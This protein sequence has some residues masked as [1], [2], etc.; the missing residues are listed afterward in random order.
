MPYV[1][2]NLFMDKVEEQDNKIHSDL[3]FLKELSKYSFE[4]KMMICQKYSSR[5]MSCSEVDMQLA[6]K[7]NIMPWELETFAAFSV[8]YNDE[9]VDTIINGEAFAKIITNIRNYWHPELSLAEEQGTYPNVF[10]MIAGLHEFPVQGLILQKLFRY[11]YFFTFSNDKIDMNQILKEN[12]ETKYEDFSLFAFIVF[13]LMNSECRD[14]MSTDEAQRNLGKVF[15]LN[16]VIKALSI[17]IDEYKRNLENLYKGKILDYY[18]GLKIQYWYPLISGAEFTYIPSPYLIINAVTESL[19]NRITLNNSKLRKIFGKEI[20]ESYLYDLYC[21]VS[22]ITWI[23][24]EI[25]YGKS[26]N[27]TSDVLVGEGEFCTF[28]DTKALTPSLKIRQFDKVE[29][30]NETEIYAKAVIQVYQQIVNY[31]DGKFKLE[32]L[33][34]KEHLFGV[35]VVLEDALLPR[36]LIY[37]MAFEMWEKKGNNVSDE[38]KKYIQSH[39]KVVPLRQIEIMI[40]QNASFLPCLL[41]QV[42]KPELWNNYVLSKPTVYN[43]LIPLYE[44]YVTTLKQKAQDYLATK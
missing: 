42:D 10:M 37:N 12:F 18:Y 41:E 43:G 28:Y 13:L 34:D 36:H 26:K 15:E 22:G 39:V 35:V 31:V 7:E 40:L 23:S 14:R 30:E 21:Q 27:K 19:L 4:S 3:S 44:E 16:S 5:I 29:I 9:D 38:V 32:E 1:K 25:E 6:L 24:K 8:V 20:I 33:Y 17:D 11:N 2:G